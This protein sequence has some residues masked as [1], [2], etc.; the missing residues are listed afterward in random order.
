M[1]GTEQEAKKMVTIRLGVS[2]RGST[3]MPSASHLLPIPCT[4]EPTAAGEASS[5]ARSMLSP[6][7]TAALDATDPKTEPDVEGSAGR[8]GGARRRCTRCPLLVDAEGATEAARPPPTVQRRLPSTSL[9][10]RPRA[11]A[12]A[13][14]T[15]SR[16]AARVPP[17]PSPI[18]WFVSFFFAVLRGSSWFLMWFAFTES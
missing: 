10:R 6:S 14:N 1:A 16:A 13:T 5:P 11:F 3:S 12:A 17:H 7:W 18:Y 15:A 8:T 9:P 2:S 4:G